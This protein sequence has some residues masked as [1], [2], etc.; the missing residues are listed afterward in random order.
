[1]EVS[2]LLLFSYTNLLRFSNFEDPKIQQTIANEQR[3]TLPWK[4]HPLLSP[5][6]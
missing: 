1:M 2:Y 4:P 6:T 5:K 3:D